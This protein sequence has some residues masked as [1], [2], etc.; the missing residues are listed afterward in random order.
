MYIIC[1][2]TILDKQH[3][4]ACGSNT[5]NEVGKPLARGR[6]FSHPKQSLHSAICNN[7][8]TTIHPALAKAAEFICTGSYLSRLQ[9]H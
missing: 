2:V 6:C 9:P 8:T 4:V 3:V 7:D 1:I 5:D